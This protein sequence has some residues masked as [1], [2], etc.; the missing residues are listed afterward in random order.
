MP[1][2]PRPS[3]RGAAT[4]AA[5]KAAKLGVVQRLVLLVTAIS[6]F[7]A[8]SE[9][10]V[11][12]ML[13]APVPDCGGS[14][15]CAVAKEHAKSLGASAVGVG[16]P[17]AVGPEDGS[18]LCFEPRG[19]LFCAHNAPRRCDCRS[20]AGLASF[21]AESSLQTAFRWLEPFIDGKGFT[22]MEILPASHTGE[23]G[24][25]FGKQDGEFAMRGKT[26]MMAAVT[27]A[28]RADQYRAVVTIGGETADYML[29][30]V[31][32]AFDKK[33]GDFSDEF[34]A[35]MQALATEFGIA[36]PSTFM[37]TDKGGFTGFCDVAAERMAVLLSIPHSGQPSMSAAYY[38]ELNTTCTLAGGVLAGLLLVA[39]LW[40]DGPAMRRA[41][42]HLQD[43]LRETTSKAFSS[44][45]FSADRAAKGEFDC[46]HERRLT[47][48]RQARPGGA[49]GLPRGAGPGR[50]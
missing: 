13:S 33:P 28:F 37:L 30:A 18:D 19:Y 38:N 26:T 2:D 22:G 48:G 42:K 45:Q 35:V 16:L 49:L 14:A 46:A 39:K 36:P 6:K 24:S 11:A 12:A 8:F 17:Y 10:E 41:V 25:D 47:H 5:A 1:K 34:L 21:M 9:E 43:R 23:M 29:E 50:A 3:S 15:L 31:G 20:V 44:A 32:K 7:Y 27:K 40:K 4:V